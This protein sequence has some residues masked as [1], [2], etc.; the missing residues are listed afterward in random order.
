MEIYDGRPI[1]FISDPGHQREYG[2]CSLRRWFDL[3]TRSEHRRDA[4]EVRQPCQGPVGSGCDQQ[5]PS[6]HVN[7]RSW[8]H[9]LRLQG[10][11]TGAAP[12]VHLPAK[13]DMYGSRFLAAEMNHS[14]TNVL[15]SDS[16]RCL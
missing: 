11:R 4:M 3:W 15:I 12:T 7:A 5:W 8:L 16:I 2:L 1:H 6:V 9:V 10:C 13:R 14:P